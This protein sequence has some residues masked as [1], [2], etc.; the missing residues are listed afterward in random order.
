MFKNRTLPL[1]IFFALFI[2]LFISPKTY[3]R[4]KAP[5]GLQITSV[6]KG[7]DSKTVVISFDWN[8]G[9]SA[10]VYPPDFYQIRWTQGEGPATQGQ[11]EKL[12]YDHGA[13][14]S[15]T[16]VF[17]QSKLWGFVLEACQNEVAASSNCTPWSPM[18]YYKPYGPY[19]CKSPYVWRGA[20]ANDV[21]CVTTQ[22]R[23]EAADDNAA[24]AS[25]LAPDK[26]NC[27]RGFV[28]RGAIPSDHVCVTPEI[29]Q[30]A[31]ED[32]AQ[33]YARQLP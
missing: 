26:V 19:M 3:A 8:T 20:Y 13:V 2:F 4:C 1:G 32:N 30:E 31:Q 16:L 28:W 6:E 15:F 9:V 17:D 27:I 29:R 14:G 23:Q 22:T 12:H 18:R 25:R 5:A 7:K 21:I 24:A 10:C 33:R 11:S